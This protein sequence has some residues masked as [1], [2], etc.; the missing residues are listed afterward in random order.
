[1]DLRKLKDQ[2]DTSKIIVLDNIF[3]GWFETYIDKIS[4][5]IP[6]SWIEIDAMHDA[7]KEWA[8][9][10]ITFDLTSREVNEFHSINKLINDALTIDVIPKALPDLEVVRLARVRFNGTLRGFDLNPHIDYPDPIAWVLVY[11]VND[12]DGDTV[13]YDLDHKTEIFRC[14][15]KKGR[16]VL[17]PANIHHKAEAPKNSPLRIS[18]GVHYIMKDK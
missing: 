17:F 6:W 18:I 14:Q 3:P 16:A 12:S 15:Y 13:F 4:K 1:M 11:Y 5:G 2:V 9:S 10:Y 7:G 8:L